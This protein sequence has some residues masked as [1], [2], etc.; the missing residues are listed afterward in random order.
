MP[1]IF[2]LLSALLLFELLLLSILCSIPVYFLYAP[3]FTLSRTSPNGFIYVLHLR[4]GVTNYTAI[5]C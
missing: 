3:T 5:P 4:I 2:T 1:L